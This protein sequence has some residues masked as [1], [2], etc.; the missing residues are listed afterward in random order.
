MKLFNLTLLAF[1]TATTAHAS[2]VG[3][4][5]SLS[6]EFSAVDQ[7]GD[8]SI[9]KAE[10]SNMVGGTLD[11]QNRQVMTNLDVNGD[12]VI[13]KDE[14]LGFYQG[15]GNSD[16][17]ADGLEMKFSQ[18]DIDKDG[19][20]SEE[21]MMAFR[22]GNLSNDVDDLYSILDANDDNLVSRQEFDAFFNQ[23][24]QLMNL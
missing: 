5:N 21:E 15:L 6:S 11:I 13:S 10:L 22:R 19:R 1:L 24:K 3:G 18:I 20:I 2:S 12:G 23:M 16:E 7:N 14:Y 8:G 9:S 17:V 4:L